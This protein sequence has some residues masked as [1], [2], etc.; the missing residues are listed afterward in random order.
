M[1]SANSKVKRIG[2]YSLLGIASGVAIKKIGKQLLFVVGI[3][4]VAVT[5]YASS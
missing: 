4:F 5:V 1:G 2:A 3:G